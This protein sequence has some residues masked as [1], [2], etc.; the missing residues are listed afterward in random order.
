MIWEFRSRSQQVVT[1][2]CCQS[3]N[4]CKEHW[5]HRSKR[6]TFLK[7]FSTSE[8]L[9][10]ET[11]LFLSGKGDCRI[12]VSNLL[13]LPALF[14][15]RVMHSTSSTLLEKSPAAFLPSHSYLCFSFPFNKH[16][17]NLRRYQTFQGKVRISFWVALVLHVPLLCLN[18]WENFETWII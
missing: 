16:L 3:W 1:K 8:K 15:I 18:L 13:K 7:R 5:P 12:W 17:L 9:F 11:F 14:L 10:S 6:E 2:C 4:S